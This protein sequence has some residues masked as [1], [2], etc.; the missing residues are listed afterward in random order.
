[1]LEYYENLLKNPKNEKALKA[2]DSYKNYT[3]LKKALATQ[4]NHGNYGPGT[5]KIVKFLK[6][7]FKMTTSD[8]VVETEFV[9]KLKL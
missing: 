8:K 6:D 5:Q 3:S 2:N 1:M 7:G 4:A 9:N